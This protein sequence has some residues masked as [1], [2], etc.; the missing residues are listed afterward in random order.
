MSNA[1]SYERI[2]FIVDPQMRQVIKR[3]RH[4]EMIDTEG[5]AVRQLL[6]EALVARGMQTEGLAQAS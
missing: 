3:F 1:K 6:H 5:E 4:Q 2:N